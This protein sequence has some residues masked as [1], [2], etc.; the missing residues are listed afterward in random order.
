[1]ILC[2]SDKTGQ[3]KKAAEINAEETIKPVGHTKIKIRNLNNF[4]QDLP[5]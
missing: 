3:N 5:A 2:D 1:M 4:H